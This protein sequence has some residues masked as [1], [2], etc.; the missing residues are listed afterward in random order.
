[1]AS[2]SKYTDI[3]FIGKEM[4]YWEGDNTTRWRAYYPE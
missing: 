1:M 2:E 3:S 4:V